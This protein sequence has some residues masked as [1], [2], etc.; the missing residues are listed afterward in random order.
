MSTRPLSLIYRD[1]SLP[2]RYGLALAMFAAAVLLRFLLMPTDIGLP[3]ITLYPATICAFYFC[4]TGPGLLITCLGAITGHALFAPPEWSTSSLS[5][6]YHIVAIYLAGAFLTGIVVHLLQRNA[7]NLHEALSQLQDSENRFRS[8]M[9]SGFFMSWM[10]DE[11]SRYIYIN[12]NFERRFAPPLH[13]ANASSNGSAASSWNGKTDFDLFPAEVAQ[14]FW[15]SD[16]QVIENRELLVA[17][18][19]IPDGEGN[20]SYWLTTKFMHVGSK[21]QN[22]IG[23]IA[24]DITERK[25]AEEKI[26]NL[27]FYDPLTNLPNRRLLL[28]RLKHALAGTLRHRRFGALL[29]IDLDNFKTLNDTYGH[30]H[31]DALLQQVAQRL[32]DNL[33]QGDTLARIGGDEFVVLLENL[34]LDALDAAAK[35]ELVGEKILRT[36]GQPY[37]IAEISHRSTPSI[38]ITLFGDVE[39]SIE[40]PLRRADLAMYQAKSDGRNTLRFFDPQI[41]AAVTARSLLESDLRTA[42]AQNRFQLYYQPQIRHTN[43]ITGVEALVRWRHPE[44]GVVSPADFI[45]VAE[46]TGLILP[47]GRWVLDTACKQLATWSRQPHTAHL[48]I[49]VNVSPR[50]F[51]Q[52]DFVE[53]VLDAIAQSNANPHRLKL[54]LT[55]GLLVSN[56]E[57]VTVKMVRLKQKG[58]S[59][60][61]DDFGTGYSSLAYLKRLPLDQLKIDQSFIRDILQDPNDAAIAK[62]IIALADSLGLAVIAEGV[63]TEAQRAFLEKHGCSAYQGYLFSRPLPIAELDLLTTP[64]ATL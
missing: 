29:F 61:L 62:T 27:A 57:D 53:Q 54:E 24:M 30:N 63:E 28:D 46:E 14:K 19:T 35:V 58:I 36:L 32:T 1:L 13:D 23:G 33:R 10:K 44:R 4:G 64:T 52:P 38:G 11:Q 31:G 48:T 5:G 60:S 41:Q 25:L 20:A 6:D 37:L 21:G 45:P 39:E 55:E 34:S 26:E 47:L 17:E 8:F 15:E 2:A 43:E 16:R 22:F 59:F 7:N 42:V 56:V 51:H 40:E 49:A 50:Q 3:F 9:D 18:D 12:R